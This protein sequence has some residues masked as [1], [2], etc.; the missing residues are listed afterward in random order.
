MAF[1]VDLLIY[2]ESDAG[3][4]TKDFSVEYLRTSRKLSSRTYMKKLNFLRLEKKEF[5]ILRTSKLIPFFGIFWKQW[6]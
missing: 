1:F 2:Q 5:Q 4:E 3:N 6:S